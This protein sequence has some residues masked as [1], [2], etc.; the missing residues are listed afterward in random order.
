MTRT[1]VVTTAFGNRKYLEMAVDLA[2]SLQAVSNL[3][4]SVVTNS[5]GLDY[6]SE[7]PR[8]FDQVLTDPD[9]EDCKGADILPRA[10]IAA[11][12]YSPYE[13][14]MFLDAD[15]LVTSNPSKLFKLINN[16][17]DFIIMGREHSIETIGEITHNG[18]P[19][20][21]LFEDLRIDKYVHCFLCCFLFGA[22]GGTRIAEAME[23]GLVQ[24]EVTNEVY[25]G[26]LNDEVLLGLIGGDCTLT[27]FPSVKPNQN[28]S[29]AFRWSDSYTI[30]HSAP[31]RQYELFKTI[32]LVLRNRLQSQQ[33]KIASIFWLHELL[34]RRAVTCGL[35]RRQFAVI[36]RVVD[37]LYGK[38]SN[39]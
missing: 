1:G 13:S 10:K 2:L 29:R 23:Y 6:L 31:M 28:Q 9:L 27:F 37:R 26:V 5:Q 34:K 39:H 35:S 3:P 14:S 30:I 15:V 7:L 24:Y 21:T 33:S 8:V 32:T 12:R 22:S 20:K 16:D 36:Q 11:I 4:I 38:E 25:G 17:D 19:V 18:L